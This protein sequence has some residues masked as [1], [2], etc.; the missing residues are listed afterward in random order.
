MEQLSAKTVEVVT[1]AKIDQAEE[2]ATAHMGSKDLFNRAGWEHIVKEHGGRCG[3]RR[4]IID[5]EF[6]AT[7]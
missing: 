4:F 3:D 6:G 5:G 1:Q 7:T 2:F